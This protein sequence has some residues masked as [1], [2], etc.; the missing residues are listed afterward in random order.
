MAT[1]L[2]SPGIQVSVIDESF[3]TPA[4]PGT[5]P[6]I[7]VASAASKANGSATGTAQGTLNA[8]AG[9]VYVITSQRD[10]TDTFGTPLFP[11]DTS[12]NAINGGEIN[13]YG[14]QAAY[15]LLGVSSKVYVARADIDLAQLTAQTSVPT[16]TPVSGTYWVDTAN[17]LFGINEWNAGTQ[18]FTVKSP[19]VIDSSNSSTSLI[20]GSLTPADSVGQQ[21]GYAIVVTPDNTNTVF[22]KSTA[23]TSAWIPV[24]T[25][26]GASFGASGKS[27][28]L[29]PHYTYPT[30]T[31]STVTGSVWI[32]TTEPGQG[33]NWTIKTYNG[34]TQSF[35]TIGAPLYGDSR[36]ALEKLDYAGGGVNI[37][38]GSVFVE[39]DI[40]NN[41]NTT[42][43]TAV[44]NFKVY[45][46]NA[47]S[48][49]VV[50][51]G[52]SVV[53]TTSNTTFTIRETSPSTSTWGANITVTIP[54]SATASIAQQI[55]SALSAAG[56][57]YVT[58]NYNATTQKVSLSHSLGGSFELTDGTGTPL[59][60]VGFRAYNLVTGAGTANLYAAPSSDGFSFL[61]SNWKPLSY[62]ATPTAPTTAPADGTLWYDANLTAVDVLVH[63]GR[64][65]VGYNYQGDG[66][67]TFSSPFYNTGTDPN[68]PIVAALAPTTQSDGTPLIDGD[69]WVSTAD[70][71]MY[72]QEIYV[73]SNSKQS[74]VLQDP[75]DQTSPNGWVFADA[76]WNTGGTGSAPA[77]IIN[78]LGSNYLDPD[79]PDPALYPRGTR[80][81][82]T[83]R[84]GFN[85]KQYNSGYIN[86]NTTN[87]RF[88]NES[89]S[90]YFADRWVTK[91]TNNEDG[92]GSFGR[93]AQRKV[94][95]K[96]LKSLID[97][98]ASVRDTDTLVFNLLATPGYPEVISNMVGLNTDRGQTAFVL[99]DTPFRLKPN[100]TELTAW[101]LNSNLAFDNGDDGAVT[102]DSYMAMFYPSGL[103]TD[104]TGNQIVVPASHMM[105]RTITNSD[106]VSYQWFAP[107]GTRRGGVDNAT[108]VGYVDAATGEFKTTA[109]YQGLR[110]ILQ[111]SGVAINPITTLPGV[112]IVNFGQKTRAKNSSALDRINVARLVAYL[113]R[114]LSILAKPYLFEP[115][116][117]QTRREIKGA[118][119]SLLLELVG[120]R[121][122]NDFITV[123]DTT[124]NTPA[125]I[126]R[127]ELWLDIAI[128]PV[129]AVEFIYIPLRILNTGAIASGN[130][131]SL[132]AGSG[133]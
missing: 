99:G 66:V 113:R 61:A 55:P 1:T 72:G 2:Q 114:Q 94:V 123:C 27:L 39:Y 36:Q 40:N 4:S 119:D 58:A 130:L 84:S 24:S 9:K 10:L 96:A 120:Q 56:L 65:W 5:V 33:A 86:V 106:A 37:P 22:Y 34:T 60:K 81:F 117:A 26:P 74:W 28:Q 90:T 18:S 126:D 127:S 110:D 115:N 46:R 128:E 23:T 122:L 71:D 25:V 101:G 17:S 35:S 50:T 63:N 116:D 80:L 54:G 100:G 85:V 3:Y 67:N 77:T 6:L 14:L 89:M 132:S 51:G 124:N 111:S 125:R 129:K 48:P 97:T 98:N 11:T 43:T 102:Y 75:S 131:G 38:V 49:T 78:L 95:V 20:S 12:G 29:S 76:R 69:I 83:R 121:A 105:L 47:S 57:K 104:N 92:S 108:S 30:W 41:S 87:P 45:R 118:A 107:A 73:W 82:N 7:F 21:G 68:G 8:N 44:A 32:K 31:T 13:E 15:S 53:S 109:L 88:A 16:G 64:T 19:I 103:T 112:G 133:A 79:A 59:D 62:Q 42:A 70:P 91:S 93:K 52:V